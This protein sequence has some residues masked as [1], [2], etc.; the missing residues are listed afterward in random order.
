MGLKV[1]GVLGQP[2]Q[3]ER[4]VIA[5]CNSYSQQNG[6]EPTGPLWLLEIEYTLGNTAS[7][8]LLGGMES[9][10]FEWIPSKT[11]LCSKSLLGCKLSC[12]PALCLS[13]SNVASVP[14]R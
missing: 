2:L 6:R 12:C 1:W 10:Q 14:G 7:T 5:S 9:C 4:Q 3:G 8:H 13:R 11:V